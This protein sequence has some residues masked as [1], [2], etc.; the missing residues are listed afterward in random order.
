LLLGSISLQ[1]SRGIQTI[2]W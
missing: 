1:Y 2:R